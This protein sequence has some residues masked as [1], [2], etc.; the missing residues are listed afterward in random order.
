[1]T[2]VEPWTPPSSP[3]SSRL[4]VTSNELQPRPRRVPARLRGQARRRARRRPGRRRPPQGAGRAGP[5][6]GLELGCPA[7]R[8]EASATGRSRTPRSVLR[9]S[10]LAI[11]RCTA[12]PQRRHWPCSGGS[13][14][15]SRASRG[16][17]RQAVFRVFGIQAREHADGGL[18]E[19]A[20]D[21]DRGEP[22]DDDDPIVLHCFP[23]LHVRRRVARRTDSSG[24]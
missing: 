9:V 21:R 16:P 5:Y 12:K 15:G 19:W 3:L 6:E 18:G 4:A 24:P 1:M 17:R 13:P 8:A 22:R 11:G 14:P 2:E 23:L 7:R 10:R 20:L